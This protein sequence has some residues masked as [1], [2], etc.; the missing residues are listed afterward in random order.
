MA[1]SAV[2][3]PYEQSPVKERKG[4]TDVVKARQTEEIVLAACGYIG[5]GTSDVV[6]TLKEI[7]EQ[8]GYEV[9]LL[10]VSDIIREGVGIRRTE[11]SY[12][13]VKELQDAGN[14]LRKNTKIT[15]I[16]LNV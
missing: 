2:L 4:P 10:K 5:S 3:R 12:A 6:L 11:K 8:Y 13:S 14:S 1:E 15:A 9:E 7:F 16:Y